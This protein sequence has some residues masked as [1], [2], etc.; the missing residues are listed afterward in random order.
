[1][2]SKKIVYSFDIRTQVANNFSSALF[3][4]YSECYNHWQHNMEYPSPCLAINDELTIV[5]VG[6]Q[7]II[8]QSFIFRLEI[9]VKKIFFEKICNFYQKSYVKIIILLLNISLK[10]C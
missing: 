2:K 8:Y 3:F 5:Y 9:F 10:L 4:S 1:M 6:F 7:I